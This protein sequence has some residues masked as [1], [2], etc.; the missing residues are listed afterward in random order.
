M[1]REFNTRSAADRFAA[2]EQAAGFHTKTSRCSGSVAL[3][4]LRQRYEYWLVSTTRPEG[5]AVSH[6]D[7]DDIDHRM[8]RDFARPFPY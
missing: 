2:R 7:V 3:A 8:E 1:M 6:H 5:G 4:G